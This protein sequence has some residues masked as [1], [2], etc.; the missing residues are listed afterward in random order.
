MSVSII[1]FAN[2][3][4]KKNFK[5]AG[6]TPVISV[7]SKKGLL[8][9]V[10]CKINTGFEFPHTTTALPRGARYTVRLLDTLFKTSFINNLTQVYDFFAC[11]ALKPAT[12][13]IFHTGQ[14]TPRTFK[15]SQAQGAISVKIATNPAYGLAKEIH[16]QELE[17][18]DISETDESRNRYFQKAHYDYE[19]DYIIAYSDW[20]K[21]SYIK[22]GY[23]ENNIFVAQSDIPL[24]EVLPQKIPSD[25][26]RV[27][28]VSF[29]TPR[30]GLHYLLEAWQTLA[31][32]N[33][34]LVIVGGYDAL[35]EKMKQ[36]YDAI[37]NADDSI[38]SVGAVT[39]TSEYYQAADLFVLPTLAEGNSKAVMEAMSHELPVITTEPGRSV[40][41]NGESGY[42]VPERDANAL[43]DK[44]QY[45]YDHQHEAQVMGQSARKTMEEKKPFGES[46]YEI[47]TTILKRE[48]KVIE[49]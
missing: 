32:K 43:A 22:E 26:F 16:E 7:F 44:I 48:G 2:L 36:S 9:Q 14:S 39:D 20:V 6:I 23:P 49:E 34:E 24:P 3:G 35:P 27:L 12:V 19:S 38:I 8:R 47:Y 46:V 11:A 15:K 13:H 5:T 21:D 45:L 29:T 18:F 1:T 28:Y 41:V 37:V 40:V 31:L 42:I 4:K 33:A 17:Y 30:K 10:I 25:T